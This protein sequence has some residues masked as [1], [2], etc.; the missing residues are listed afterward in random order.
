MCRQS[1]GPSGGHRP[2]PAG[3]IS[4]GGRP[5]QAARQAAGCASVCSSWGVPS[6][7][8]PPAVQHHA[9]LLTRTR[10][11]Q[12]PQQRASWAVSHVFLEFMSHWFMS[13]SRYTWGR[14]R[15]NV[16]CS[17]CQLCFSWVSAERSFIITDQKHWAKNAVGWVS[18]MGYKTRQTFIIVQWT[19]GG[20]GLAHPKSTTYNIKAQR[21]RQSRTSYEEEDRERSTGTRRWWWESLRPGWTLLHHLRKPGKDQSIHIQRSPPIYDR[22]LW[23]EQSSILEMVTEHTL[24][25]WRLWDGL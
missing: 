2:V 9:P 7:P 25:W 10:Y 12:E 23:C 4:V 17:A 8:S 13:E 22:V 24:S 20:T 15:I 11:T 5:R 21:W 19:A 18:I 14:R 1:R 16:H 3:K 6:Q